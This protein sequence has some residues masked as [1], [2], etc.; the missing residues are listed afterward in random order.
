M[1]M[2]NV[3]V[4]MNNKILISQVERI[5]SPLGDPDVKLTEPFLIN[6]QDLTLSPWFIGITNENWFMISSD[7]ILTTF[8][9]NE[10]LLGKYQNLIK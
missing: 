5:T 2:I 8:E 3:V 1:K 4:L 6:T 7:K 9:P 10:I